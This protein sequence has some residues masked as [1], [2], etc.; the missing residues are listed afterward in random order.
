MADPNTGAS[1]F[2]K[3]QL[4]PADYAVIKD[5]KEGEISEPFESLDDEGRSGNL[6]YKI[7]KLEKI[8]PS[9]TATV[10]A[11]FAIIQNIANRKRQLDAISEFVKEKQAVT[12]IKIDDLFKQ[13]NF[14]REGWIK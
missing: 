4:K 8:V 9:H 5:M 2:E 7:L 3:D 14:E 11:D 1:L 10:E 13:C 6:I 12:Y